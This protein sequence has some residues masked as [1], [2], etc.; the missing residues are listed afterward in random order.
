VRRYLVVA[1]QTLGGPR[2]RQEIRDRVEA[3]PS[4]FYVLVPNTRAVDYHGVPAAGGMVPMPTLLTASGPTTDEEATA[5][6][7]LRLDQLLRR[8]HALDVKADGQLG[9]ADPLTAI[10]NV[11]KTRQ[12]DEVILSTLPHRVSRWLRTDLPRNVRRR[13]DLPVTVVISAE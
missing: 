8:L 2:L 1:N 12:F 4:S 13:F 9:D 10:G 5:E 11:L 6:A 7:Q 3:E